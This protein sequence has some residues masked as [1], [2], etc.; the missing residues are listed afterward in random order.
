VTR[1]ITFGMGIILLSGH[2]I[3][4]RDFVSGHQ[5]SVAGEDDRSANRNR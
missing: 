1:V 2:R 5:C 3:G 4:C